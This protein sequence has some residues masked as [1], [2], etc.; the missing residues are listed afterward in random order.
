MTGGITAM[1]STR[2]KTRGRRASPEMTLFVKQMAAT[3]TGE[4]TRLKRN[5]L[6]AMREEL[7]DRQREM[8]TLRYAGGLSV[9]EIA[10]QLEVCPSTVSRTLARGER[11]LFRAL[12]YGA[13]TYLK[14]AQDS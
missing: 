5:L 6:R 8:L 1:K 2:F 9:S 12:R 10:R 14:G 3:N 13:A 7:T 11:R 4:V